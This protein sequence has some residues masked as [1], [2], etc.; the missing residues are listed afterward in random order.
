MSAQDSSVDAAMPRSKLARMLD[1]L[2]QLPAWAKR[3]P[4]RAAI[5][6]A[7]LG[8]V[9]LAAFAGGSW[10]LVTTV[11]HTEPPPD[12]LVEAFQALDAGKLTAAREHALAVV[13][14]RERR[15]IELAEPLYILGVSISRSADEHWNAAERPPLHSVAAKFLAQA[16]DLGFPA[17][18]ELE[19]YYRLGRSLHFAGR[20]REAIEALDIH[21]QGEG[22]HVSVAQE[23]L[24][25]AA[26]AQA[27]PDFPRARKHN[28]ALLRDSKLDGT[29][30]ERAQ[31]RQARIDLQRGAFADGRAVLDQM[32]A[33][34][35]LA[36]ERAFLAGRLRL[37]EGDARRQAG[38]RAGAAEQYAAAL[39]VLR[40]IPDRDI[41][42]AMIA[43]SQ[44]LQAN[45]L[46]RQGELE[47]AARKW[48]FVR[49]Q[50]RRFPEYVPATLS[51]ASD[52]VVNREYATAVSIVQEM[53]G[54]ETH[55]EHFQNPY[56]TRED[57]QNAVAT[58]R[59]DLLAAEEFDMALELSRGPEGL[60]PAWQ[61]AEWT[62]QSWR[63]RAN[64]LEQRA[65]VEPRA[66]A[67]AFL[68][69]ARENHRAA[70]QAFEQLAAFRLATR[71]YS[72]DLWNSALETFL[73]HDYRSALRKG[74]YY[75]QVENSRMRPEALLVVGE[76]ALSLG[77]LEQS[78]V[79]LRECL[80]EHE[81]HPGAYRARFLL[82]EVEVEQQHLQEAMALLE[83]NLSND[84]LSPRSRD[85]QDSLF[86]LGKLQVR[87]G[88]EWGAK[89]RLAGVDDTDS[90]KVRSGLRDLEQSF[91]ACRRGIETLSRAVQRFPDS[92]RVHEARYLLAEAHRLAA[93]WPLKR[94]KV[95]TI[96]ST[97]VELMR[98]ADQFRR[99]AIAQYDLAI[100]GLQQQAAKDEPND[101]EMKLLRNC[102]FGKAGTLFDLSRFDD[103]VRA[104]SA[105]TYR[106]QNEPEVLEAYVR[107]ASCYRLLERPKEA[108]GML[109]Q[110]RVMLKRLPA[111]TNF[112]AATPYTREEW[113]ELLAW[114][115]T[116]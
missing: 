93:A 47:A 104:Y 1:D 88:L 36:H 39:E 114:L 109:E 92:S 106:F 31:L 72:D 15:L 100:A 32:P 49:R 7:V 37:A 26:L 21:V 58:L 25:E 13:R 80:E 67:E 81:R 63:L 116:L 57:V 9:G 11:I 99:E 54:S 40:T 64:D 91:Q 52:H 112:I 70:G 29:R 24:A 4:A 42:P 103:A 71:Q 87:E 98:Q 79:A 60:I 74:K 73:G 68:K 28:E 62:A 95:I 78:K 105:A 2:R 10:I 35:P 12:P 16:R 19:G 5:A 108:R 115:I 75:L 77:L 50:Y 85:W 65:A 76:S 30:R 33:D 56:V 83:G 59:E 43:A 20:Y 18:R 94:L 34:S 51:L 89:S 102:Y 107:I 90:E 27:P 66:Q 6:S 69:E 113:E 84:E 110:A 53:L 86:M 55:P 38:D 101:L 23:L 96:E 82:A 14:A 97:R 22:E 61:F 41:D 17:D 8:V 3:N 48:E 45:C 111:T 46:E 44:Y